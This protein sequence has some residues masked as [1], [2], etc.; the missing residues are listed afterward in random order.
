MQMILFSVTT[1]KSEVTRASKQTTRVDLRPRCIASGSAVASSAASHEWPQ[2]GQNWVE[3]CVYNLG[4]DRRTASNA[5]EMCNPQELH[6]KQQQQS[7]QG[8]QQQQSTE[9]Q[10]AAK[11][12]TPS[13]P[14]VSPTTA[15]ALYLHRKELR[16]RK[17]NTARTS[18]TK[19]QLTSELIARTKKNI[20]VC[21][22]EDLE[23]LARETLFKKNLQRHLHY[24]KM[25]IQA[26]LQAKK[27]GKVVKRVC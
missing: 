22:N 26:Y 18:I 27:Q 7:E 15:Y 20:S 14:P 6:S 3:F 11:Q 2:A 21:S 4:A 1:Q 8:R 19:I 23:I 24:R 25:A 9:Q 5:I 12:A 17:A 13:S 16:S 10:S